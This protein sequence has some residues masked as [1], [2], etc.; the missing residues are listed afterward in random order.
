VNKDTKQKPTIWTAKQLKYMEML[1]D[2]ENFKTKQQ[3]AEELGVN[4]TTL[5]DWQN[6]EGFNEAVYERAMFYLN[7]RLPKILKSLGG[8][9]E[10][11][12]V[13]AIKLA[14]LHCGKLKE[15]VEQEVKVVISWDE[16]E[17]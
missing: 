16:G 7:A 1:A 4:R 2:P 10:R 6:L 15:K 13:E 8:S 9:S 17:E 12:N 5:W 3:M 11:G 14:L